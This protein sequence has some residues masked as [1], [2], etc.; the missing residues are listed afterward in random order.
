MDIGFHEARIE[1]ID[2]RPDALSRFFGR[3]IRI[4]HTHQDFRRDAAPSGMIYQVE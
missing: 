1:V 2:I 4:K 3:P